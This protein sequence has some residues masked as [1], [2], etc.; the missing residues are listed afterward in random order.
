MN[1]HFEKI[2][3]SDAILVCNESKNDVEGY[4]GGNTFME[5]TLAYLQGLPIYVLNDLPEASMLIDELRGMQPTVLHGRLEGITR[6][7]WL[8]GEMFL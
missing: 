5:M 6:S 7:P 8:I 2:R 4:I 1:D 3:Q